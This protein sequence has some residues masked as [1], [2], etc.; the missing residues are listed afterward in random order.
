MAHSQKKKVWTS[1]IF[2]FS[3][4]KESKGKNETRFKTELREA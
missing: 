2:Y 4:C 1:E 3:S